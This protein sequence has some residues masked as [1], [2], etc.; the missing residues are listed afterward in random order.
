MTE[1]T[2]KETLQFWNSD[3]VVKEFETQLLS[4]YWVE[5]F[6]LIKNL[7]PMS[8]FEPVSFFVFTNNFKESSSAI[9]LFFFVSFMFV[10]NINIQV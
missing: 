9:A 2:T 7:Y 3:I 4:S 5:F 8:I 6:G 10:N 1:D